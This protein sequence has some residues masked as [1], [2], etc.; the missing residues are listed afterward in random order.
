[1]NALL[2]KDTLNRFR[3]VG[4]LSQTILKNSLLLTTLGEGTHEQIDTET[5]ESI[6]TEKENSESAKTDKM[7]LDLTEPKVIEV[8]QNE[9]AQPDI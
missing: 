7:E 9:I 3:L 1:M 2:L 8:K 5:T 6:K 4:P